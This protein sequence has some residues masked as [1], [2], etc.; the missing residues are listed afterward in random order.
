MR[1]A[2]FIAG[3]T[4]VLWAVHQLVCWRIGLELFRGAGGI[5]DLGGRSYA[6]GGIE[7][8]WTNVAWL[9]AGPFFW[10][11]NVF[12][13]VGFLLVMLGSGLAAY[14]IARCVPWPAPARPIQSGRRSWRLW[15]PLLL[16]F[17]W[18]PVPVGMAWPFWYIVAY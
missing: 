2:W 14:S 11:G 10:L 12:I 17:V 6:F 4:A 1:R 15:A 9:P 16:W 18:V 13:G 3:L 7:W 8:V 5:T